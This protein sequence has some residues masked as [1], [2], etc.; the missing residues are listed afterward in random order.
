MVA[1]K[2][3]LL[4]FSLFT[5]AILAW[6]PFSTS[7]YIST[8][9]KASAKDSTNFAFL[10]N[11]W[12]NPGARSEVDF[13]A[14]YPSNFGN[15]QPDYSSVISPSNNYVWED[16]GSA[17][18]ANGNTFTWTT[19]KKNASTNSQVG[20]ATDGANKYIVLKDTESTLYTPDD[21]NCIVV[22]RCQLDGTDTTPPS[23]NTT[24]T[25]TT[26]TS[27]SALTT[28]TAPATTTTA[29]ASSAQTT[30]ASDAVSKSSDDLSTGAKAGIGI[31]AGLG[32]LAVL[33][34]FA[35]LF[36]RRR[37]GY[38]SGEPMTGVFPDEKGTKG[39]TGVG[40]V[41]MKS[42]TAAELGNTPVAELGDTDHRLA[43]VE[44]DQRAPLS[45]QELDS[46]NYGRL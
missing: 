27:S 10:V 21:F 16:G 35:F 1:S 31:G 20:T 36:F 29:P 22:Y 9:A 24:T 26:T 8:R 43:E 33:G 23:S 4:S 14:N 40:A 45:P 25:S 11:C 7:H 15:A 37:R 32:G 39:P 2:S 5:P 42:H 38:K 41:P 46:G 44:G 30:T 13:F 19:L 6:N 28:T 34:T 12:A 3:F 17:E 18:D